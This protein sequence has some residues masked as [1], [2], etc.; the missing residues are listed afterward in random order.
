[1]ENTILI[2]LNSLLHISFKTLPALH[3]KVSITFLVRFSL[4]YLILLCVKIQNQGFIWILTY[5]FVFYFVSNLFVSYE[6]LMTDVSLHQ[7]YTAIWFF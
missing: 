7:Q 5:V 1:M 2:I 3:I 6:H 4:F